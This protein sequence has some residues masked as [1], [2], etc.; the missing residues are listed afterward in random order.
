M[1]LRFPNCWDGVNLDSSDHRSHMAYPVGARCPASHPVV[2]P[3]LESFF[4]YDV[5]TDPIGEITLS[6]GPYY[7][8]HQDFFN[9]WVPSSLQTLV[10]NCINAMVDCGKN[11]LR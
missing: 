1:S 5:G 2:L 11:P 6:S 8:A 9:A 10:E 7:T 4:R 3:R